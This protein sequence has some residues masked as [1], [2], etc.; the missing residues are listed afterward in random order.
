M[1]KKPLALLIDDEPTILQLYTL[2]ATANGYDVITK[3]NAKEAISY[4]LNNNID[5]DVVVCD[6]LKDHSFDSILFYSAF[7]VKFG[8]KH[9]RCYLISGTPE[10]ENRLVQSRLNK[11]VEFLLKPVSFDSYEKIFKPVD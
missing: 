10:F 2:M 6:G 3:P 11:Y 4:L 1:T 8:F 9:K 5:L 7:G